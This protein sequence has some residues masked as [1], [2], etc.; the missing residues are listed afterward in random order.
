[1]NRCSLFKFFK[2]SQIGIIIQHLAVLAAGKFS[3]IVERVMSLFLTVMA[4]WIKEG[5]F[6]THL[7]LCP[8]RINFLG[9][10]Y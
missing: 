9:L 2:I 3:K 7:L 1:M 5:E 10:R 8:S 4:C 6:D